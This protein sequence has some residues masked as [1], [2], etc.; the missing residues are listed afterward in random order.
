LHRQIPDL[1][2]VFVAAGGGGLIGGVGA[3]LK[4]V[5]PGV[6]IVGCWPENSPVLYRCM[7]DGRVVDVPE[8][9]TLSEST[10]G[11]LEPESITVD[12]CRGVVDRCVFVSEPEILA[13]MR[14]I[15]ESEHWLVEGSAGVA[16]TAFL[17][18]AS[19]YEGKTVAI[20]LC[21]RNLSPGVLQAVM[22]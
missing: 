2:A 6:E 12:L 16:V 21:G 3:Y 1:G 9:P 10:S 8:E 5:A 20:V 4:A 22:R 15:L 17:K 11:G 18:S 19:A 14:L 7:Q 13:A